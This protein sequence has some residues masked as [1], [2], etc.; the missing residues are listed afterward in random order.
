MRIKILGTGCPNCR[1]LEKNVKTAVSE[2]A[3]DVDIAKIEDIMEI[4]TYNV[5]KTPG[6]VLDEQVVSWGKVLTVDQVKEIISK[7]Q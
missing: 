6:L 7:K 2:L 1:T 3:I 5:V 4:M